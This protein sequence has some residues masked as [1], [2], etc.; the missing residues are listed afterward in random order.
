MRV[1]CT[2]MG[3]PSHGR[4]LLPL[5]RAVA[6]AGHEVTIAA[7][8]AVAHVFAADR[9]AVDVC[10]PPFPPL[11]GDVDPLGMDGDAAVRFRKLTEGMV[12]P[13]ARAAHPALSRLARAVRPDLLIRDGMDLAA[14]L[15]AEDLGVP[16]LPIPS[17]FANAADPG[18]VRAVLADVRAAVGLPPND[19]ADAVAPFGRFDYLPAAYSFAPFPGRVHAYRQTTTVERTAGLPG[20]VTRLPGDRPL[21]F[22]AIGTALPMVRAMIAAGVPVPPGMADPAEPLRHIVAGLSDL[23]C[24]AVVATGGIP[25]DGPAPAPHVHVTDRLPQPLLLECADLFV[26]HGGYNSVREAIRTA[27]PMVVLPQFGD[28]PHNARRVEALGLGRHLTDPAPDTLAAACRAVLADDATAVR[29]RAAR[30]AVLALPD[31]A[32]APADLEELVAGRRVG[33]PRVSV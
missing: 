26:T 21:V 16:H 9:V 4:A 15:V 2:S 14:C 30:L 5:A 29:L 17:G 13:G 6:D 10:L 22:A 12:G 32:Q 28:Q 7:T 23:D 33:P 24:T 27:T 18:V 19:A 8:E 1:L 31:L 25:L 3:S 11:S 20:W